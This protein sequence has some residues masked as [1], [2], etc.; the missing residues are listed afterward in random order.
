MDI[1]I[2]NYN[3]NKEDATFQ[4]DSIGPKGKIRKF[5][6][7]VLFD[8]LDDGTPILNLAFGDL[9]SGEQHFSDT[10]I[11][12]NAD[13]DKVLATVART[14]IDITKLYN[15]VAILAQGSTRSRTRLYQM[16]IHANKEEIEAYF[17]IKGLTRSGWENFKEGINYSS[18]LATK[19]ENF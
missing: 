18:L 8:R 17:D 2:Y 12:N 5:V 19:K 4:F 11:S 6:S 13:S 10:V 9:K 7:Y 3:F 16:S 1:E 15:K 14:T